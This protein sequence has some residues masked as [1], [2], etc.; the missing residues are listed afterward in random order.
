MRR[1]R[2]L[3]VVIVVAGA[4]AA[5]TAG[6]GS[7]NTPTTSSAG[8]AAPASTSSGGTQKPVTIGYVS[9]SLQNQDQVYFAA[10]LKAAAQKYGYSV[11]VADSGAD[12]S[13]ADSLIQLYVN[14]HVSAIV[15]DS[16][17]WDSLR[18]GM[19]AAIAAKIPVYMAWAY[20]KP[21][22]VAAVV[23]VDAGKQ[24]GNRVV[25]DL[26]GKGAALVMGLRNG[27]LCLSTLSEVHAALAKTSIKVTNDVLPAPGWD[28]AAQR[29]VSAWLA[30]HPASSGPLAVVS[31]WDGPAGGEVS[32]IRAAGKTNE[33]K[34]YGTLGSPV[35][36]SFIKQ[37]AYTA[38]WWFNDASIGT[39]IAGDIH[40]NVHTPYAQIKPVYSALKPVMVDQSNINQFLSAHPQVM[41][42][43]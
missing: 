2:S 9:Y 22:G 4:I 6:C 36:F 35:A 14:E 16:Y 13:K 28:Q 18:Q 27:Q 3:A 26:H 19:E 15:I 21:K 29:D 1:I 10:G 24:E 38:T 30:S 37:K 34:V 42:T 39:M 8:A 20:G 17:P 7:S 5:V 41:K 25:Q 43:S 33:V 23:T 31:C 40:R 11:K 12:A 32:A